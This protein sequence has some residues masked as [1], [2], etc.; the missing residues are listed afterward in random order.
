M[1]TT[2]KIE[3]AREDDGRWIG[4]GPELPGVLVHDA[5]DRL[6]AGEVVPFDMGTF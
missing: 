3:I 6:E 5:N 1:G 4:E 2:R